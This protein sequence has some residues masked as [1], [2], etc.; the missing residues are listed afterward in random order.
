MICIKRRKKFD[1]DFESGEK[2]FTDK[3]INIKV[4]EFC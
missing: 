2:G 3:V 4:N 1:A